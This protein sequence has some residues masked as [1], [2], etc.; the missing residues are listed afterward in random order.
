MNATQ[1][2]PTRSQTA[3]LAYT[4]YLERLRLGLP[5]DEHEDWLRAER[6]LETRI[7]PATE[8][9]I[10][11]ASISHAAPPLTRIRG[12]GPR[13]AEQLAEA[14][15]R[16]ADDLARWTLADFGEK[17]PRLAARA[18]SGTWIEQARQASGNG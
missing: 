6:E 13:V 1:S 3:E 8:K 16:N 7:A 17:L 15:I 11:G 14:G 2:A 9:A 18:K 5:S 4:F 12:I 10:A